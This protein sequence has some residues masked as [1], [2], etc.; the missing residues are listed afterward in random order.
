MNKIIII[1]LECTCWDD[2]DINPQYQEIIQI[3][4]CELDLLTLTI[5]KL[6][7]FIVKPKFSKVSKY[8]EELTGLTQHDVDN[9][10]TL[11]EAYKLIKAEYKPRDALWGAWSHWDLEMFGIENKRHDLQPIF[12]EGRFVNLKTMWHMLAPKVYNIDV[13][14]MNGLDDATQIAGLEFAG[15]RRHT[16][17]GDAF[18]TAILMQNLLRDDK[19][20]FT[21]EYQ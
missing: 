19:C 1:D 13:K 21:K 10:L 20:K 14:D 16:G 3:G 7:S 18:H 12:W 11:E 4:I 2:T 6:K 15:K 17:D 8:C 9:G 5:S